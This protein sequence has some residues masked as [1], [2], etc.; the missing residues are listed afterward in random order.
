[1]SLALDGS[2]A[3]L[4]GAA[5]LLW[6]AAGFAVRAYSAAGGRF[7]VWWLMTLTGS[8]GVFMAADLVSFYLMFS[9]VSLAAYGLV[10]FDLT[11][12]ALRA[13][14]VY[15]ALAVLG[16]AFLLL[17]FVMLALSVP[18][19]SLS[20]RDAVGA[21]P[22]S[23]WRGASLALIVA[24]FGI[25]IGMVP[26][27]G[28]MPLAYG[29]AP[30]PA[31]SVLSGA[32]VK[33]GVIGL[34]RFLPLEV[35]SPGWGGALVALGLCSA[36]YGVAVGLTQRGPRA[37]LAY[38]S[39][40]Q[41]GVI[42]AVLGMGWAGG[43]AGVGLLVAFYAAHHVLAKGALFLAIGAGGGRVLLLAAVVALGLGGLPLTGGALAKLAVKGPLGDGVVGVL[44][45]VSAVG[46]TVLMLH[47]LRLLAL[48]EAVAGG[49]ELVW[50]WFAAAGAAV[51]LPWVL[52]PLVGAVAYA[53]E[54][55]V[56]WAG[57]WPVLLGGAVFAVMWRW[58]D[59]LPDVPPGDL[60]GWGERVV[61][62][63]F[64]WS[65]GLERMDA[66][67]RRWPVAGVSLLALVVLVVVG[68]R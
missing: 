64:G 37:V 56:L 12:G 30:I 27:H 18:G 55:A 23:A 21:L 16:E 52:Y 61:A 63:A 29:A 11:P 31:A 38:S 8:V 32:A 6:M 50:A 4:L 44:G 14:R 41:M 40:S 9:L 26:L 59:R 19:D 51:L 54:P 34:I 15:V 53:F 43:D 7:V 62:A 60:A 24:G 25:K 42:A 49:R 57:A 20:I 58:V 35:A 17:G 2:G 68:L 5:A 22:G 36:F 13:G 67:L 3:M 65:A 66:W 33:A 48:S 1:M 45:A 47:F 10:A 39:V 46:T 28:W